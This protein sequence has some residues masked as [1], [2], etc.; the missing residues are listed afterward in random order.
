MDTTLAFCT[1]RG[2]G[3]EMDESY[4]GEI[5]RAMTRPECSKWLLA[6]DGVSDGGSNE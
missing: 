5:R 6:H 1:E 3:Q 2:Q 4:P